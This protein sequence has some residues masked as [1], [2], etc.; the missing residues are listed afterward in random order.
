MGTVVCCGEDGSVLAVIHVVGD[1]LDV[2]FD[3]GGTVTVE[4]NLV[5]DGCSLNNV[6]GVVSLSLVVSI[7]KN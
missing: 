2:C 6:H 5:E 3:V 1:L 4:R 7:V